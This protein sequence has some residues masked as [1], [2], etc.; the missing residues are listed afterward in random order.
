MGSQN[1]YVSLVDC[2]STVRGKD[3]GPPVPAPGLTWAPGIEQQDELPEL[4]GCGRALDGVDVNLQQIASHSSHWGRTQAH[5]QGR[6][7]IVL[8]RRDPGAGP[9]ATCQAEH[10][11]SSFGHIWQRSWEGKRSVL[12]SVATSQPAE[13]SPRRSQQGPHPSQPQR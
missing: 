4:V 12:L 1:L 2:S 11:P 10:G 7:P 5:L 9:T 3:Q 8:Q 6:G 13:E